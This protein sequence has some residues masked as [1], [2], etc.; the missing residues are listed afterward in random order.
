MIDENTMHKLEA[1]SAE[2][3]K[4]LDAL[5][6]CDEASAERLRDQIVALTDERSRLLGLSED[7]IAQTH[8]D[9][10]AEVE[11]ETRETIDTAMAA[12]ERHVDKPTEH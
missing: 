10:A 7:E 4:L 8:K 11:A 6:S 12:L 9:A 3:Q 5:A 2:I 1:N